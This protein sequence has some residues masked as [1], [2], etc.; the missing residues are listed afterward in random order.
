MLSHFTKSLVQAF[1]PFVSAFLLLQMCLNILCPQFS[2]PTFI[3]ILH[4]GSASLLLN[5]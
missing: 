4:N 3:I 1:L 2:C 5:V